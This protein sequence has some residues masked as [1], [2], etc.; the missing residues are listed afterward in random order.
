MRS[1]LQEQPWL[2][3]PRVWLVYYSSLQNYAIKLLSK[4]A[5][6]TKENGLLLLLLLLLIKWCWLW[7]PSQMLNVSSQAIWHTLLPPSRK[8]DACQQSPSW[9]I[10]LMSPSRKMGVILVFIVSSF[11]CHCSMNWKGAK[12]HVWYCKHSLFLSVLFLLL[13]FLLFGFFL[14]K[15]SNG[16]HPFVLKTCQDCWRRN[17]CCLPC[18][19]CYWLE[20]IWVFGK[21]WW[22]PDWWIWLAAGL[23]LA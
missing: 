3:G 1:Q 20:Y 18:Y 22:A 5:T 19:W 14:W 9:Y 7:Q 11:S 12:L 2:Q 15:V 13:G 6:C 23:H 16:S 17:S 8:V 4:T 10:L 21:C